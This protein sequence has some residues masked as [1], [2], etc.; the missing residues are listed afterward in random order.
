MISK[1]ETNVMKA[2]AIIL[3]IVGHY[4]F[5]I[6]VWSTTLKNAGKWGVTIFLFIS[7]YGVVLSYFNKG[8]DGFF[9]KR[10]PR[11]LVPYAIVT[12]V[13]VIVE[14]IFL[15][16]K[17]NPFVL[18]LTLI[19]IHPRSPIDP[20][21]WYIPYIL[22]WY[23]SFYVC[24]RCIKDNKMRVV[25]LGIL[26]IISL[27]ILSRIFSPGVGIKY[28]SMQFT[29]GVITAILAVERGVVINKKVSNGVIIISLCIALLTLNVTSY[30]VQ[31]VNMIAILILI[32]YISKLI[33]RLKATPLAK[34]VSPLTI[35]T[36]FKDR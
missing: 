30:P 29:L 22:F 5:W 27:F 33:A 19:G 34:G 36:Q 17:Y 6:N 8:L 21:M 14:I 24:F 15:D 10:L 11:I 3:I 4:Q 12:L 31:M 2:M 28:Y 18:I 16:K 7:G 25:V 35:Q 13:L 9:K 23:I 20:T 1:K 32:I 26:S